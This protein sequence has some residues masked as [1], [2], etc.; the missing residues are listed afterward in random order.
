MKDVTG[1]IDYGAG[2]IFSLTATLDRI[3]AAYE[4]VRDPADLEQYMRLIIPGVGHAGMAMDRLRLSGMADRIPGLKVPVLGICVGMQL[5]TRSSEEGNSSLLGIVP[6]ET[7][8]FQGRIQEKVPHMGWN[9]VYSDNHCPIFEEVDK[10][11]YFYFVHSYF[12]PYDGERT[13]AHTDYGVR[14]SA[15]FG[16]DNF[17]GVQFHPE[18]S[19]PAG[20]RL[21]KNFIGLKS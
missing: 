19:G 6:L 1:I 20:E 2:N 3:G 10:D 12:I 11:A 18:K 13:T 9:R 4:L 16:Q 17:H 15:A 7:L 21:L 5:L 14:F 8:H